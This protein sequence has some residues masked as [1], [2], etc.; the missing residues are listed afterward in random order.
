MTVS[1]LQGPQALLFLVSKEGLGMRLGRIPTGFPLAMVLDSDLAS[2]KAIIELEVPSENSC[3]W[4]RNIYALG[5]G[6][7]KCG[8]FYKELVHG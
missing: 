4:R 3:H 6:I 7:L 8:S 1:L 5:P 2:P